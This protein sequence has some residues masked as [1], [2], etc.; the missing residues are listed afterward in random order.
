MDVSVK[1]TTAGYDVAVNGQTITLPSDSKMS[2]IPNVKMKIGT[3]KVRL[4]I[5]AHSNEIRAVENGK[6]RV[7][8]PDDEEADEERAELVSKLTSAWQERDARG[9][10]SRRKNSRVNR[11]TRRSKGKRR[12][13]K[14]R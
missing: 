9:G 3:D 1:K 13:T 11:K 14:R 8:V 10:S 6:S 2:E 7:I 5:D 12:Y 4:E